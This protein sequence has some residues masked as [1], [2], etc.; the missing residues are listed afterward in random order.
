MQVQPQVENQLHEVALHVDIEGGQELLVVHEG[1]HDQTEDGHLQRI[2]QHHLVDVAQLPVT[3]LVGHDRQDLL[4]VPRV[5]LEKL[6]GQAD[7]FPGR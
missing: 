3:E 2:N 5:V 7:R 6:R 1:D 4:V